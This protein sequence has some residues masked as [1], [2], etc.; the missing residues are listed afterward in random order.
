[1]VRGEGWGWGSSFLRKREFRGTKRTV[2]GDHVRN[3][4]SYG[5]EDSLS[6]GHRGEEIIAK[7]RLTVQEQL[8]QVARVQ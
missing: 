8:Q 4:W 6:R 5:K 1:M 7:E 3:F 2:P